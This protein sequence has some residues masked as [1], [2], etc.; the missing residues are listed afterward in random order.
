P[1]LACPVAL[2]ATAIPRL[3]LLIVWLFHPLVTPA[4]HTFII[5]FLGIVF[6]PFT[7]LLYVFLYIPGIGLTG[8]GWFWIVIGVLLDMGAY[9]GS[10]AANR[11]RMPGYNSTY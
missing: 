11:R 8:W 9:G 6:L 2:F 5:P 10:A 7:T 3:A 4:F 1:P